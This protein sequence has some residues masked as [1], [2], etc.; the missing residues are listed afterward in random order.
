MVWQQTDTIGEFM[1]NIFTAAL[2]PIIDDGALMAA[3][4]MLVIWVVKREGGR[5]KNDLKNT[6]ARFS[7]LEIKHEELENRLNTHEQ[8]FLA[9]DGKVDLIYERLAELKQK[10]DPL[11]DLINQIFKNKILAKD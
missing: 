3:F 10:I 7:S 11:T 8:R 4:I 2:E 1:M 6:Q 5:M 9:M